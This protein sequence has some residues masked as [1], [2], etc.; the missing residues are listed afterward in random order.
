MLTAVVAAAC[1]YCFR[2][3]HGSLPT[4]TG[5]ELDVAIFG[6]GFFQIKDPNSGIVYY[7]RCG[8]LH[9][10]AN[11]QLSIGSG[12]VPFLLEPQI[13]V[14]ADWTSITLAR[15]GKVSISQPSSPQD[16][17]I[18]Q[19]QLARFVNPE[20]LREAL[21]GGN[22][23]ETDDAGAPMTG[24]PGTD[25]IGLLAQQ[26]QESSDAGGRT[27]ARLPDL[28]PWAILGILV[29]IALELRRQRRVMDDLARRLQADSDLKSP[30]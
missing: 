13:V 3:I 4:R 11:G 6:Q 30:L 28:V 16:S 21:P 23:Q 1:A 20:G 14:P 27:F 12:P 2:P 5:R 15:D 25:G 18:G 10:N 29:W 22:L 24:S 8:S 19:I 17:Q 7:T 9:L 26:W